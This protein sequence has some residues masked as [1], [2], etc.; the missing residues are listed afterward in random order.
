MAKT[1]LP[2]GFWSKFDEKSNGW[3]EN[4]NENF[5]RIDAYSNRCVIGQVTTA[6]LP[7]VASD[8]DVYIDITDNTIATWYCSMWNKFPVPCGWTFTDT[9]DGQVYIL[10]ESGSIMVY[11]PNY[12]T[13]DPFP[14]PISDTTGVADADTF[15]DTNAAGYVGPNLVAGI[16]VFVDDAAYEAFYGRVGQNGDRYYDSTNNTWRAYVNG[17]WIDF[18]PPSSVATPRPRVIVSSDT[19]P[20]GAIGSVMVTPVGNLQSGT[21]TY[22]KIGNKISLNVSGNGTIELG[23]S[24]SPLA[25]GTMGGPG[26]IRTSKIAAGTF[27]TLSLR[28]RVRLNG[29][30]QNN[31][32][33]FQKQFS[34]NANVFRPLMGTIGHFDL[35]AGLHEFEFY[36]QPG[37]QGSV[38]Y[39][40][41]IYVK[42]LI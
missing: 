17:A 15:I 27:G 9:S 6:N 4:V 33:I 31:S 40:C 24:G 41:S 29:V 34:D 10:D 18:P 13:P 28:F 2:N 22:A 3:Q 39:N 32:V 30:D 36:S 35:P 25:A 21:T 42:E 14:T 11:S 8:G 5:A 38:T 26:N 12:P 23:F 37:S 20:A 16:P 19:D 1:Q 7:A